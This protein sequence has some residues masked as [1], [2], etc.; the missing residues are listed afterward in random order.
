[1][2]EE[3]VDGRMI[4]GVLYVPATMY[5]MALAKCQVLEA[6]REVSRAVIND[7]KAECQILRNTIN[8]ED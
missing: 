5:Q 8:D 3:R 1:M 2:S 6:E 7:L 4:E